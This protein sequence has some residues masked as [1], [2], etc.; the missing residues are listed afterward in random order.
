MGL[1]G[2]EC[3]S[4]ANDAADHKKVCTGFYPGIAVDLTQIIQG[5]PMDFFL[6][7]NLFPSSHPGYAMHAQ[8]LEISAPVQNLKKNNYFFFWK[9]E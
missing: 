3:S 9:S 1:L 8:A 2:S 7:L 6:E 4:A 5:S